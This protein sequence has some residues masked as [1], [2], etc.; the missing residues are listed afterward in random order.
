MSLEKILRTIVLGGIFAL[1]F[2]V[3]YVA[4]DLFFPFITGKNLAFRI[5]VEITVGAWLA[6]A[7]C[8]SAYWP[9]RNWILG[10]FALFVAVVA[11]A[12]AQGAVP[13]KSFWSNYERMD[14]WVTLAHLFLYFVVAYTML[15]TERLWRRYWEL[16]LVVSVGLALF[17]FLQISGLVA[18]GQGGQ[19]SLEARIDAT[20]GNPIYLA[21]YMLFNIFIAAMLWSWVWQEQR[22]RAWKLRLAWYGFVIAIDT[23]A[24]LFTGTRGTTLGLVGGMLVATI[25]YSLRSGS[26]SAR[27]WT[28]GVI[29]AIIVLSLAIYQGRDTLFVKNVGFLNRLS[30]ISTSDSTVKARFLNW[31]MAWRG[32]QERPLLGW[33]QENYAIVFDKYYDPRMYAQEQWFDRVHN[34]IFDW[35]IAAGLLGLMSYLSLFGCALWC[36]YRRSTFSVAEQ[37]I[38]TGLL[39][40][41]F[42]HNLFVFDNI[43]SYIL[44]TTI[45]AFVAWRSITSGTAQPLKIPHSTPH[46]LPYAAL[47]CALLVAGVIW[48]VNGPAYM[49][50]RALLQALGRHDDEL[51]RN[52]DL[53]KKSISYGTYGTQ[54]AREQLVQ[55]AAQLASLDVP[56]EIKKAFF[57]TAAQEMNKQMQASPLDA[58]FPLFLGMLFD[59]YGD[60]SNGKIA[61][62]KAHELSPG[63]QT[64]LYQLGVNAF[65]RGDK[66][67]GLAAFKQ[68]LD[69]LPENQ[70]ARLYYAQAALWT[71]NESLAR[72]L[73]APLYPTKAEQDAWIKEARGV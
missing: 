49:A 15:N 16:S 18:L 4:Y 56:I 64:I 72:E 30:T 43:T 17:G 70:Q 34:V 1:P 5:I 36:I 24:L 67:A 58:R 7:L 42:F 62:E 8:N 10:A 11:I 13:F 53:F 44:F 54:E 73:V 66:D 50:N 37:S 35:L 33:G 20:L 3:F 57:E 2:I 69:L 22:T 28:G 61:F 59:S 9:K 14:G 48:W 68:A 65:R 41:Y 26:R 55:A 60:F 25:L 32:F 21:A 6:L 12:D 23:I 45:L 29:A 46:F 51:Q 39:A 27:L 31:G 38:L 63:K 40:A 52:L 71:G 19:S 47:G